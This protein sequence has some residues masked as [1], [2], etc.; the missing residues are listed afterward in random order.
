[1]SVALPLAIAAAIA[2]RVA[3]MRS[4]HYQDCLKRLPPVPFGM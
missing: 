3:L 4:K 1:M 2:A